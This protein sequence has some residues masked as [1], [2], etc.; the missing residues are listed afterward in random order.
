ME[1][2][3]RRLFFLMQTVFMFAGFARLLYSDAYY[4]PY[5]VTVIV[6]FLCFCLN[7]L[8]SSNSDT[9]HVATATKWIICIFAFI[10]AC[11]VAFSNYKLWWFAGGILL[12]FIGIFFGC[13]FAFWNIFSWITKKSKKI[14]WK[15]TGTFS[16]LKVFFVSFFTMVSINLTILLLCKYPG[17]MTFDSIM[18][19]RQ[20][21][22]GNYSNHHPFYHTILIKIFVSIGLRLFNNI[23]A[24]VALYS[25]FSVLFMAAT[26]SFSIATV[27]E[28]HAPNWVVIILSLF[29]ALMPYHIMYSFTMWKDVFFGAFVLLFVVFFFRCNEK[30]SLVPLNFLGLT[31]SGI[32]ICLFRSNGYFAFVFTTIIFLFLGK[33]RNKRILFTMAGVLIFS[34]VLKHPVL[35]A[36]N[37]VQ[38]DIAET[39]SVPEQQIARD[40]VDHGDL[41]NEERELLSE[42]I[43]IDRIPQ[44]YNPG[45]ADPIKELVRAKGNQDYIRSHA[46]AF[47]QLYFSRLFEHPFTYLKAWIDQTKGYWNAGY[48]F[49]HWSNDVEK[50]NF[51]IYRTTQTEWLDCL[52]NKYLS[53]FENQPPFIIFLCIGFFNWLALVALFV[54]IIRKDKVGAMLTVPNIMIV[55]SLLVATP[56]FSEFRYDYA[57]FCAL[58]ILLVLVLRPDS[59]VH[60][61]EDKRCRQLHISTTSH[62]K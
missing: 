1:V 14:I 21:L 43:D 62:C 49:W 11:M 54:S 6:A 3:T 30:M 53:V 33:L 42:V 25:S 35:N 15:P 2:K 17:N 46:P 13:F 38:P 20:V 61:K 24:A 18:Q 45:I 34:F 47:V 26:F 22:M 8:Q 40:V 59:L 48:P 31:L 56:V 52:V 44:A 5:L 50:N 16:P 27:A 37:V 29:F 57:I 9:P 32:G 58:P 12:G 10:F 19:M 39:L 41:T 36:L 4:F 55:I 51:G 28:L 23:N 60:E 7:F